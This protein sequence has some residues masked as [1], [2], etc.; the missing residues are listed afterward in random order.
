[1]QDRV[2]LRPELCKLLWHLV[3]RWHELVRSQGNP[4]APAFTNRLEGWLGRF[5]PRARLTRG[6]RPRQGPSTLC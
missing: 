2:R 3:E 1:M 5:K 4:K 6:R